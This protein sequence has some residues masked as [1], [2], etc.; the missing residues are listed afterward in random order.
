MRVSQPGSNITRGHDNW[1]GGIQGTL[2][3]YKQ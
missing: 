3:I 2:K 1:T